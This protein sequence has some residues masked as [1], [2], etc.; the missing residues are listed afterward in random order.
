V[1]TFPRRTR[2]RKPAPS[3]QA[4]SLLQ[5]ILLNWMLPVVIVGVALPIVLVMGFLIGAG[6]SAGEAVN[7]GELFLAG[8]NAVVSG[9]VVLLSSRYDRLMD[10]TIASL[11]VIL[12]LVVPAY[13]FWAY[14]T[15]EALQKNHYNEHIASQG[16][17]VAALVGCIVAFV[18]VRLS[19]RSTNPTEP[20]GGTI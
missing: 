17:G 18:F 6:G 10:A 12:I 2:H 14:L 16:G 9:C 15:T 20:T 19:Y 3:P 5:I 1:S 7:H 11:I 8:G 4:P 13:A